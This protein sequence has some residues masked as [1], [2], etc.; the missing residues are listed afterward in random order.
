MI[1]RSRDAQTRRSF[2]RVHVTFDAAGQPIRQF[3][4]GHPEA[5]KELIEIMRHPQAST[6]VRNAAAIEYRNAGN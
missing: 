3:P 5:W 2:A 1:K 6:E 4:A